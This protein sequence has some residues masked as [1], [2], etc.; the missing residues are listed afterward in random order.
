MTSINM[1]NTIVLGIVEASLAFPPTSFDIQA[2]FINE[3]IKGV[4]SN[5][6]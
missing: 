4:F 3:Q 5:V 6:N 2:D 1:K